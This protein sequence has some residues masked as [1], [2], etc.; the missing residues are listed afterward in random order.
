MKSKHHDRI[1]FAPP[2]GRGHC[3]GA[4]GDFIEMRLRLRGDRIDR[5]AFSCDGC[6]STARAATGLSELVQ[7]AT[8]GQA[9]QLTPL[10]VL[11]YVGELDEAHEHC[12]LIAVNALRNAV[13]DAL[14][15]RAEPWRAVYQTGLMA[16]VE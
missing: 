10:H 9:L 2:D 12:A 4:C 15:K 3:T 1:P 7:G 11:D 16:G 5:A 6:L 13:Q 14:R 8:L